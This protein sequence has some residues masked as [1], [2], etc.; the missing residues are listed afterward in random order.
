[1]RSLPLV[2]ALAAALGCKAPAPMPAAAAP[3]A[4]PAAAK[5]ARIEVDQPGLVDA[6][7]QKQGEGARARADRGV[8][9]VAAFWRAE[10]GDAAALR[11]FVEGAFVADPKQL[12]ALLARFSA[13]FEQIDGHMLEIGRALRSWNEL[14]LGPQMDVDQTFAAMDVSAHLPEDLFSSKLAFVALLN[15]P[16]PELQEMVAQ[17]PRWSR[18]Q[19][20]QARLTR[21]FA[22]RPGGAALQALAKAGADA[23]AYIAGYNVWMHHVLAPDGRRLFPKGVRLLSH[24]N[25]RDQIKVDYAEPDKALALTRQRLIR[26]VMERI[27]TQTIPKAV[28]DDPRVEWNPATNTVTATPAEEVETEQMAKQGKRP[29]QP[30]M[31]P[32]RE[33]DQRYAVLLAD[34][35]AARLLDQDSPMAKTLIDRNFQLDDELPEQR[36]RALLTQILSSPLVPRVAGVI[37]KRLGRPLE[38]FDI[39][40]AGFVE[41]QPEAELSKLTRAKYP[42]PEAYKKDLPRILQALGFSAD[43]AKFLDARIVVD[44]ARGSGHALQA[45]RRSEMYPWWGPGDSPHL[46]VRV[47]PDGM[48]Y[49]NYSTVAVH[50]L[51]HN[52]EQVFSL[53]QVDDTLLQGVPGTAFTEALAFTFQQRDLELLGAAKPDPRVEHTRA[54]K[55]FWDSWEIAGPA[56]VDLDVWHWM[57]D[58]TEATP[59]QLREATVAIARKYWDQY[60]APVLGKPG[61]PQL[62]IYSHMINSFLYLYRYPIGHL[63]EFQLEQKLRGG[64]FGKEFERAASHGR[65]RIR[66]QVPTDDDPEHRRRCRP[67]REVLEVDRLPQREADHLHPTPRIHE[68]RDQ[69]RARREEQEIVGRRKTELEGAEQGEHRNATE[70]E[71]RCCPDVAEA[72]QQSRRDGYQVDEPVVLRPG[73]EPG[74]E[75]RQQQRAQRFAR[76]VDRHRNQRRRQGNEGRERNVRLLARADRGETRQARHREAAD[77]GRSSTPQ[78]RQRAGDDCDRGCPEHEAHRRGNRRR[79]GP[80]DEEPLRH[81]PRQQPRVVLMRP[82]QQPRREGDPKIVAGPGREPGARVPKH[83][84]VETPFRRADGV[85]DEDEAEH[86]AGDGEYPD[87]PAR[88]FVVDLAGNLGRCRP[89]SHRDQRKAAK[90]N[91]KVLHHAHGLAGAKGEQRCRISRRPR[92]EPEHHRRD[93]S[94]DPIAD[95]R[96]AFGERGSRKAG[97][98]EDDGRHGGQGVH[99]GLATAMPEVTRATTIRPR[100]ATNSF[101]LFS[102]VAL[103]RTIGARSSSYRST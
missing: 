33:P 46:R 51:G 18:A 55:T 45:G 50:E 27:V 64:N 32:E 72:E 62:A 24:W 89:A 75:S 100:R 70:C 10:D 97:A 22:V 41:R 35:R 90:R 37:Q 1:M 54:L 60:Y 48:D 31:S 85:L 83:P 94:Q 16:Q 88:R 15:F 92:P 71:D 3:A 57:Y 86:G 66:A 78:P 8:R 29:P 81:Q 49:R 98:A 91:R 12:D 34:F 53:Y 102:L 68:P 84:G 28:I 25:L 20:A 21:R 59:A 5:S 65:R 4:T 56:L 26:D 36:V 103:T 58:H 47:N 39:W 87:E 80:G 96:R 77:Q 17:G 76:I 42:T 99:F 9:Q 38:P 95:A 73:A 74:S 67:Q 2:F 93:R 61:N 13:A 40:Y 43:K 52:V 82:E 44:P 6:L 63:I 19:W 14:E 11:S 30:S 23:E 101:R 7:V 69:V 79:L